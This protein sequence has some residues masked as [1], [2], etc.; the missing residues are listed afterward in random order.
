MEEFINKNFGDLENSR[1]LQKIDK[2]DLL[3]SFDFD[4][5]H[6]RTQTDKASTWLVIEIAYPFKKHMSQAAF[7]F[8]SYVRWNEFNGSSFLTVK[9]RNLEIPIF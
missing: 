7:E 4:S 6:P 5:C 1:D 2:R 9:Y 8:F 3:I